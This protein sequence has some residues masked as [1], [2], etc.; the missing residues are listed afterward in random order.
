MT[1]YRLVGPVLQASLTA[2]LFFVGACGHEP[3]P[4]QTSARVSGCALDRASDGTLID[5]ST[6]AT[7]RAVFVSTNDPR[8]T[9]RTFSL[10]FEGKLITRVRINGDANHWSEL[11][12]ESGPLMT[13]F[14]RADF[15]RDAEAV[16]G[17]V[18]GRTIVPM[19]K[20]GDFAFKDGQP[21]PASVIPAEVGPALR[22]LMQIVERAPQS[23]VAGRRAGGTLTTQDDSYPGSDPFITGLMGTSSC[24]GCLDSCYGTQWNVCIAVYVFACLFTPVYYPSCLA[25]GISECEHRRYACI[26]NCG[27]NGAC[28][29]VACGDFCC[30][31]G[32]VCLEGGAASL[33]CP[34]TANVTCI[35]AADPTNKQCCNTGDECMELH[36]REA[37]DT[38]KNNLCCDVAHG[39][40]VCHNGTPGVPA[41]EE[42]CCKDDGMNFGCGVTNP[43]HC[44]QKGLA[45][46]DNGVCCDLQTQKCEGTDDDCCPPLAECNGTCCTH[47]LECVQDTVK[48]DP[49]PE[50]CCPPYNACH[51]IDK[52]CDGACIRQP[53]D[54]GQEKCCAETDVACGVTDCCDAIE[55]CAK[56]PGSG[57][58]RC[59]TGANVHICSDAN[60][61]RKICCPDAAPGC[62]VDFMGNPICN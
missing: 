9:E 6:Y 30:A 59:C 4:P 2:L 7:D 55:H 3:S 49:D 13:G 61:I 48:Y 33:C 51:V 35:E 29:P 58:L 26:V 40:E 44:C 5:S 15:K 56:D 17:I 12:V 60:D 1:C 34:S 54:N 41:T 16:S 24:G 50:G 37:G 32:G 14:S 47:P 45:P 22:A 23:C 10:E 57:K 21:V 31:A 39:N 43:H 27:V 46:C 38:G 53:W 8:T 42:R 19:T 28:C 25:A 36:Q 62:S 18:D 52:C 11:H 20:P